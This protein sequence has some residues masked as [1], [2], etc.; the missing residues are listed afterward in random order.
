LS[1]EEDSPE[2][3]I[4][5]WF[6]AFTSIARYRGLQPS[7][8]EDFSVPLKPYDDLIR[9][10]MRASGVSGDLFYVIFCIL[11]PLAA[12]F[13]FIVAS[14][15]V[16]TGLLRIRDGL[17]DLAGGGNTWDKQ[18]LRN[19]RRAVRTSDWD[20]AGKYAQELGHNADAAI[21]Y[22]KA[23][24][25]EQAGALF[26]QTGAYSKAASCYAA[27][28]QYEKAA[29][30]YLKVNDD[31]GAADILVRQKIFQRGDDLQQEG[32]NPKSRRDP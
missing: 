29:D 15:I 12:I 30:L 4:H 2:K 16:K 32:T 1:H 14:G 9:E 28:E 13:L 24:R 26:E 27:G 10:I 31:Q 3:A 25:H 20:S 5:V 17:G 22:Q 18:T 8:E 7:L 23:G 11:V 21:Y 19:L 6:S